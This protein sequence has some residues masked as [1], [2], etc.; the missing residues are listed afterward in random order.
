[1][2]QVMS[3][4]YYNL[5]N[6]MLDV[7]SLLLMLFTPVLILLC[8]VYALSPLIAGDSF[9]EPFDI[10]IV[11][12]D[13]TLETRTLIQQIEK[14]EQLEG[15]VRFTYVDEQE[16]LELLKENKIASIVTVPRGFSADLAVG[17]NTPVEVVGNLQRPLQSALTK[18]WMESS[19]DLVTAAQSGVNTIYH[20]LREANVSS[21]E[22][23]EAV[24]ISIITFSLN[25]LSR[26]EMYNVD[27]VSSIN[28]LSPVQYYMISGGTVLLLIWGLM[29][30]SAIT[31][32]KSVAL[33][34]RLISFGI[35][36]YQLLWSNFLTIT[37]ILFIKFLFIFFTIILVSSYDVGFHIVNFIFLA[38]LV[39]MTMSAMFLLLTIFI[40]HPIVRQLLGLFMILWMSFSGGNIVPSSFLPAWID[41]LSFLSINKWATQGF[42]EVLFSTQTHEQSFYIP[43]LGGM[44]IL[45]LSLAMI[46][47]RQKLRWRK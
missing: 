47:S 29:G 27:T 36:S 8:L 12:K 30:I 22:L 28:D 21:E 7:R 3:L 42:I 23:D 40:E 25:A 17:K 2:K 5:K 13:D 18:A 24:K 16:A 41:S 35:S 46:M 4:V 10:A 26:S 34:Q 43:A 44:L 38:L 1:M 31:G 37:F 15:L 9:I 45:F 6:Y 19:A 14:S 32:E 33:Q 39:I 20:F 11:N